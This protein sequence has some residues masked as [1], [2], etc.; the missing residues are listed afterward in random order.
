MTVD[1]IIFPEIVLSILRNPCSRLVHSA[2]G[3][4]LSCGLTALTLLSQS[5]H[6][7]RTP[8]GTCTKWEWVGG[9]HFHYSLCNE[10]VVVKL[11]ISG[12]VV[13]YCVGLL[14][15]LVGGSKENHVWTIR[16]VTDRKKHRSEC[17]YSVISKVNQVHISYEICVHG[18]KLRFILTICIPCMNWQQ[19]GNIPLRTLVF[20]Y[21]WDYAD[22]M[23][24]PIIRPIIL[25]HKRTCAV[26]LSISCLRPEISVVKHV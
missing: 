8:Q 25:S 19:I 17:L 13:W 5:S 1:Q 3:G 4:R 14:D 10:I 11:Q 9:W 7:Y 15:E 2:N 12:S 6:A 20:Y 18:A 21:V 22:C 26:C 16:T 24:R 23:F